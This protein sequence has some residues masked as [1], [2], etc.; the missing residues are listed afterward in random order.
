MFFIVT[1]GKACFAL[2]KR[3]HYGKSRANVSF[4]DENS[5]K[6]GTFAACLLQRN[7]LWGDI[8]A[9]IYKNY[10]WRERFLASGTES[11]GL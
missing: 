5:L 4:I 6:N 10:V 8:G 2:P 9:I 11:S 1:A 7:L 3:Q